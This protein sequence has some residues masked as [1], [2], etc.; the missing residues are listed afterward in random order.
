[1]N[2]DEVLKD[3]K[4][5]ELLVRPFDARWEAIITIYDE[6]GNSQNDLILR[7]VASSPAQAIERAEK[8]L[9]PIKSGL[10]A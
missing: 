6:I 4:D 3:W 7:G 5:R 9:D 2:I 10:S 8:N 1:M